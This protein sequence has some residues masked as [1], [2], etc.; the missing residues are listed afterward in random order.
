MV[1]DGVKNILYL[2]R[3]V[4]LKAGTDWKGWGTVTVSVQR[5]EVEV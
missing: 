5:E 2:H 3:I 1:A 4:A